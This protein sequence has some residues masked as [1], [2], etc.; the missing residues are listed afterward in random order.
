MKCALCS[1]T[2]GNASFKMKEMMYGFKDEFNY[3]VCRLCEC[4]QIESIPDNL[5][6]FYPSH[7]YSYHNVNQHLKH[8]WFRTIQCQ[9]YIG[10]KKDWLHKL[11]VWKY[12]PPA[13]YNHLKLL[14]LYNLKAKVVDIGSGNGEFLSWMYGVGYSDLTGADPFI[15]KDVIFNKEFRLL[16]QS[17]YELD[18]KFDCIMLHHSLEHMDEQHKVFDRLYE[19]LE[20]DGNMLIRIPIVSKPLMEEYG[21]NVVSLDPPRHFFIH[22]QKSFKMLAEQHGFEIYETVFDATEFSYW[23]SEQYKNDIY[24]NGHPQSYLTNKNAFSEE[25]INV[26]RAKIQDLNERSESDNV[27]YYLRKKI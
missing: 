2:S 7:Y 13:F 5:S 15:E 9:A 22:S 4:I 1:N 17:I 11:S 21:T 16:K 24:L 18:R 8:S 26:F 27:C 23:A 3:F 14:K 20:P 19:L 6:K 12:R 25:Q 10:A